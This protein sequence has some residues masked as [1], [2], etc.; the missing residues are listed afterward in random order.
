MSY[1]ENLVDTLLVNMGVPDTLAIYLRLFLFLLIL[2]LF[3]WLAFQLTKKVFI[4][5]IYRLFKKTSIKWDDLLVEN[6]V[7]N[8]V[9]HVIPAVIVRIMAPVIFANFEKVLP[10]V[11]KLT[12]SYLIIV[13]MTILAAFLKVIEYSL[14]KNEIFKDKPLTSYF[15]LIKILL[16]IVALILVLSVLLGKSPLYFLSA[17]GAISAILLLI[18][19]DTILGLVASVQI[20]ANDMVH[21]G[22]WVEMPKFNADGDVIAINLNTVKVQNWDKTITTI[23]TYYFITDSFKNWRGMQQSGGRR[24]KRS[25]FLD[26]HSVKFVDPEM[27]ERL[28]KYSLI[29]NYV[30]K[31]QQEIELYNS[32]NQMDTSVLINGR[33]MTNIGVFR[34]YIENYLKNHPRINQKMTIMVRQLAME[35]K[36]IPMEIYCFT[37]TTAWL[38]YEEIQSD[39]FDHLYSTVSFFDLD[40]FQEP[41]G[42]DF[43]KL[44][45]NT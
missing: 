33:R 17:F 8:N 21:V 26:A 19:K 45:G 15:Q 43:A 9:A 22:D 42:K 6:K 1:L 4:R 44:T 31:R 13:G 16:Y 3:S 2:F 28:K 18:F 37:N 29:S 25:V 34:K 27:R 41:S 12:D 24:I 14:S 35:S 7:F 20:S 5:N 38:E 11:V 10:V 32:S 23:P 30:E 39:I 40:I 36:G